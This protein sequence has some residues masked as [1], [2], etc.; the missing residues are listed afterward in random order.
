MECGWIADL[1]QFEIDIIDPKV[2]L[3]DAQIKEYDGSIPIQK[4]HYKD[5]LLFQFNSDA[6][7]DN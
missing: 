2:A 5:M 7:G 3:V 4:P 1:S 6:L